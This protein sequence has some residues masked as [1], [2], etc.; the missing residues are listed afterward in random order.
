QDFIFA[1]RRTRDLWYGSWLLLG[2]QKSVAYY[3]R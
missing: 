1:A 2:D 3:E